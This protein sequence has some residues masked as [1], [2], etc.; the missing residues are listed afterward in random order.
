MSGFVGDLI[1]QVKGMQGDIGDS[2]KD[3]AAMN[4]ESYQRMVGINIGLQKV[5]D[6]I[7]QQ[8]EEE[9]KDE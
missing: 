1:M 2:L 8:L 6:F 9:E 5:L 4:W 3:G 7:E